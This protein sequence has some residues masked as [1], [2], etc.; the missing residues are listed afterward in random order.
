MQFVMVD[1]VEISFSNNHKLI[2]IGVFLRYSFSPK[3]L[4]LDFQQIIYSG[5]R[6]HCS[7]RSKVKVFVSI[8]DL[9]VNNCS[10]VFNH[11]ACKSKDTRNL[12]ILKRC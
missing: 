8:L 1:S 6:V 4:I 7:G 3:C 11:L 10:V 12:Q 9:D 2:L 5:I